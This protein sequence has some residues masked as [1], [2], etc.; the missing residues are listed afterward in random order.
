MIRNITFYYHDI[1]LP[2]VVIV[3]AFSAEAYLLKYIFHPSQNLRLIWII[4]NINYKI[5]YLQCSP[6]LYLSKMPDTNHEI[7]KRSIK[8]DT[9]ALLRC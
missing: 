1:D 9:Y 6:G 8:S 7:R 3:L 5:L 2:F 4:S